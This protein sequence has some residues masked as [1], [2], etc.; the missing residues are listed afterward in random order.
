MEHEYKV[1]TVNYS[2]ILQDQINEAAKNGW[3]VH[4]SINV[5]VDTRFLYFSVIMFRPVVPDKLDQG[6]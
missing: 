3:K 1:I 6:G 4:G 5:E 2:D